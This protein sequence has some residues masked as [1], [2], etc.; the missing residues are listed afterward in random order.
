M[1]ETHVV[2]ID[3]IYVPVKRR[4]TLDAG[5]VEAL[6]ESIMDKGQE[7]PIQIRSD[8]GRYVLITGL[9]RLEALRALGEETVE[10]LIVDARRS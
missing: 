2:K 9:Y 6:A 8:K 7:T 5:K 1:L 3:D 4:N 10:A